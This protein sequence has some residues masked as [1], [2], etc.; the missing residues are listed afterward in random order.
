[1][2]TKMTGTLVRVLDDEARLAVGPFEYQVLIGEAVRRTLYPRV[3]TEIT[4]HIT[5]YFEGN[6]AG[7]RFVPRRIGFLTEHDL[8]FFDLF[9]TVDKIGA[10]K[11]LK[12]MARPTR[13]IAEAIQRGD[14]RWLSTLP[15]IGA[16]TAEGIVTTLR[17]KIPPF[18]TAPTAAPAP[19][20]APAAEPPAPTK[21]KRNK[22]APDPLPAA[23]EVGPD[24]QLVD[25]VYQALIGLGHAPIEARGKLDALLLS[26]RRFAT[27]EEA[28]TLV[29][30]RGDGR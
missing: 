26:G 20:E 6:S 18:L 29:Y 24:G 27:M 17:R 14:S 7:S 4:F 25:D 1:M 8:D 21:G 11:A 5:E 9:C 10:K 3:G 13:E 28:L 16:T 2:I 23:T 15:G 12:A 19:T 30:S 22:P